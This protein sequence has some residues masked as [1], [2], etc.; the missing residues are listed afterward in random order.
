MDKVRQKAVKS[1]AKGCT[2]PKNM[3][4]IAFIT[5]FTLPLI[6]L[7][8]GAQDVPVCY[9]QTEAG[10]LLSLEKLCERSDQRVVALTSEEQGFLEALKQAIVNSRRPQAALVAEIEVEPQAAIAQAKRICSE[11][12]AGTFLDYRQAQNQMIAE[13]NDPTVQTTQSLYN[14]SVQ[15]VAPKYF[16]PGFDG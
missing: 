1:K 6:A 15:T 10:L 14:R 7:S 9:M 5:A 13:S 2:A 16:C 11:L 4:T 8:A 12:E 3:K